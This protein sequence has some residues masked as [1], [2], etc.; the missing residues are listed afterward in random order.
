MIFLPDF[1][2]AGIFNM[3]THYFILLLA[4]LLILAGCWNL[5]LENFPGGQEPVHHAFLTSQVNYNRNAVSQE[6]L[7]PPLKSVWEQEYLFL[8]GRGFTI[9]EEFLFFGTGTGHMAVARIS[10]GDLI[11]KKRLGKACPVPPTIYSGILYQTFEDGPAGLVAYDLNQGRILWEIEETTSRASPVACDKKVFFLTTSGKI[12]CYH[13]LTGELI[14]DKIVDRQTVNSPAFNQNVLITAGL[15]GQVKAL[16]YTS[17]VVLWENSVPDAILADP[18]IYEDRIYIATYEGNLY[19]LNQKNGDRLHTLQL[20]I[21]FY[22]APVIDEEMIYLPLG[23][24][25]ML[26]I[27]RQTLEINWKFQ[28]EGPWADSPLVTPHFIYA[29]NLDEKFYILDKKT[30][31]LLQEIKLTGRAR[32]T[33][34]LTGN[35]IILT[36]ENNL[37]AAYGENNP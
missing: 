27:G 26:A 16:E 34:V 19:I 5:K 11:G 10:D 20:N 29:P 18:V 9:S 32:S 3:R 6:E 23:S 7:T 13:Y 17:G 25:E 1:S 28:S 24:G 37:V 4:W 12:S 2:L 8:P 35:K 14:W 36:Y 21:P 30:G 22:F 31:S 15:H 33:P